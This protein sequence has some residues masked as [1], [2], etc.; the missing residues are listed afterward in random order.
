MRM[1]KVGV[2]AVLGWLSMPFAYAA[3]AP[4]ADDA[5]ITVVDDGDTPDDIVRVI[6]LPQRTA[7]S[8]NQNAAQATP[9]E[10]AAQGQGTVSGRDF[11]QQTAEEARG[12]DNAAQ[13]RA[14]AKQQSRNEARGDNAN[15]KRR[16]PPQ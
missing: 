10:K 6:E 14:E 15:D 16:G 5:T 9:G 7:P 8:G 4:D 11:G 12:R 13:V 2:V 3:D 1:W